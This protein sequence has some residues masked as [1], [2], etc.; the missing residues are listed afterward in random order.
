MTHT[1]EETLSLWGKTVKECRS[2][3]GGDKIVVPDHIF[4]VSMDEAYNKAIEDAIGV[5]KVY[6]LYDPNL[7]S[8]IN[9]VLE[10]LKKKP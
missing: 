8:N 1:K 10:S 3:F 7:V 2:M 5:V 6:N 9:R 4:I